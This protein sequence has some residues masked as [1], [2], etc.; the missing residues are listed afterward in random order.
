MQ[1]IVLHIMYHNLG[2]KPDRTRVGFFM[3]CAEVRNAKGSA[4]ARAFHA[5]GVRSQE[6]VYV[7]WGVHGPLKGAYNE[8]SSPRYAIGVDNLKTYQYGT[9]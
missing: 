2:S 3:A 9:S 6:T 1:A 7:F 5:L 8:K 4:R